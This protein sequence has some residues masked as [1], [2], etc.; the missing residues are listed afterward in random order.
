MSIIADLDRRNQLV[1][2]LKQMLDS[3]SKAH[4]KDEYCERCGL[5]LAHINARFWL[6]GLEQ[7]WEIPLPY[8]LN[9]NP[10]VGNQRS[11]AA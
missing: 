5:L 7:G 3:L 10:E 4:L 9:C 6:D 2:S 8:C 1:G 11:F